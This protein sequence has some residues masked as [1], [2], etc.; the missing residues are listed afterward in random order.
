MICLNLIWIS[1]ISSLVNVIGLRADASTIEDG[2][3]LEL[4][5]AMRSLIVV[6]VITRQW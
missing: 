6:T 1:P 4:P 3:A 5:V 2:A